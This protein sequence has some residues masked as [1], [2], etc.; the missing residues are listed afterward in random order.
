MPSEKND[1]KLVQLCLKGEKQ[2]FGKLLSKYKLPV[3][4]LIYRIV[5]NS[6]DGEDLTQETFIKAFRKL[7]TYDPKYPFLTWLF[8]IAH[9][10]TIDFLRTKKNV[11]ISIDDPEKPVYIADI[12]PL[13]EKEA[14]INFSRDMLYKA[15]DNI[16]HMHREVL[17]LRHKEELDYGEISE[18]LDIPL[19]TV[20]IR[21]FRAREALKNMLVKT[22]ET[23]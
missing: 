20:K 4:N 5:K 6:A 8:R 23:F 18:V 19:G 13:P 17:L 9:N 11:V 16:N 1:T 22:G 21:L 7:N 3:F 14:E 15:L 2:A 10:T 12:A